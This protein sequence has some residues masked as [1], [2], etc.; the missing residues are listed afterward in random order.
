VRY[1]AN[2]GPERGPL[3]R[4]AT[5]SAIGVLETLDQ[6]MPIGLALRVGVDAA[7][8]AVWELVIDDALVPGRWVVI[9]REFQPAE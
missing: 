5:P 8:R 9:D 3:L 6:P 1:F 7:G 4:D 2:A